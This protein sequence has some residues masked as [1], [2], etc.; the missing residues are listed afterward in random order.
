MIFD[1]VAVD[2][3]LLVLKIAFLVLLY[4]FIWR[5]VRT[6]ARDLRG[7]GHYAA[8]NPCSRSAMM[9]SLSS[10]PIDNRTT[11]GPAPACVFCAS[12]S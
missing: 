10:S 12:E 2:E 8:A 4:L 1:S 11:S 3:V 7:R 9:S 5:I 6:G